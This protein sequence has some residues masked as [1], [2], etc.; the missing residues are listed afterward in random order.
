MVC[1]VRP[2]LH[3]IYISTKRAKSKE[4]DIEICR[5]GTRYKWLRPGCLSDAG[6]NNKTNTSSL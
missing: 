6:A 3:T 1:T 4:L 2:Q 5:D